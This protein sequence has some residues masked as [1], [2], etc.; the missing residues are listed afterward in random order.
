MSAYRLWMAGL[1]A[2]MS[3][4]LV[5]WY[6]PELIKDEFNTALAALGGCAT[7]MTSEGTPVR[8]LHTVTVPGD[9]VVFGVIAAGSEAVVTEL[10][11]RAGVPA[12]RL[13]AAVSTRLMIADT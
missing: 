10:C 3:C 5:E 6:R 8:V 4:Y 2:R 11:W 9:E 1:A 12:E 7:T 13:T